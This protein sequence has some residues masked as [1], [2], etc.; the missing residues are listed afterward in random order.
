MKY[1]KAMQELDN[2]IVECKFENNEWKFM[3][4]RRDKSFPNGLNTAEGNFAFKCTFINDK[5]I[6]SCMGE[7]KKSCN[8]GITFTT[9]RSPTDAAAWC[10]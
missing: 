9:Y 6:F 5:F 1:T 10:H 4:E 7:Y 3:R 8:K 2:K